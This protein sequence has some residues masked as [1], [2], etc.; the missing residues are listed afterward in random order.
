MC[1]S[2]IEQIN[3]NIMYDVFI[4]CTIEW[5]THKIVNYTHIWKLGC[6][7]RKRSLLSIN[8]VQISISS[9]FIF[10]IQK[11]KNELFIILDFF[12]YTICYQIYVTFL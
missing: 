1:S 2:G 8:N 11:T 4:M 10:I 6:F 3:I 9:E 7:T 5:V 12:R